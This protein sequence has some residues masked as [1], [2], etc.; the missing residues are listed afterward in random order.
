VT[1]AQFDASISSGAFSLRDKGLMGGAAQRL[2]LAFSQGA[3]APAAQAFALHDTRKVEALNRTGQ[4]ATF[5][6]LTP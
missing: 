5:T 1:V 6:A 2:G 4:M 3:T